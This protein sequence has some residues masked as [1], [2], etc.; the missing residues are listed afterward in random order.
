MVLSAVLEDDP[1]L[2]DLEGTGGGNVE[3]D[4]GLGMIPVDREETSFFI[5]WTL[6]VGTQ[7]GC[8]QVNSCYQGVQQ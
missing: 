3:I 2:E 8:K 6:I 1:L 7:Q 4:R 5:S